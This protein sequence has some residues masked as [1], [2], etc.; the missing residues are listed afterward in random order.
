MSSLAVRTAIK[1]FITTNNPTENFIDLSGQYATIEE[2][3]ADNGLTPDDPWLGLEFI[4]SDEQPITLAA[5]NDEGKYRES[6]AIYFHVVDVAKLGVSDSILAR[7]EAIRD[8]FRGQRIGDILI[9]SVSPPNFG[10]GATLNFEGGYMAASFFVA[11]RTDK[12]I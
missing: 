5:T 12:N 4:G 9:E 8:T 11:Y 3:I 6:G 1:S 7:A 2:L 10:N